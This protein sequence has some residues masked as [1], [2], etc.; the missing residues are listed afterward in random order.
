MCYICSC[1]SMAFVLLA[2]AIMPVCFLAG[3]ALVYV[4]SV[5]VLHRDVKPANVLLARPLGCTLIQ[6]TG[7]QCGVNHSTKGIIAPHKVG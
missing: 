7:A 3:G 1:Q 4:H 6:H 2:L 5:G